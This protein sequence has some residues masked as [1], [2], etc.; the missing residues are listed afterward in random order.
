MIFIL[1][2]CNHGMKVSKKSRIQRFII[3]HKWMAG[4]YEW[5]VEHWIM[6]VIYLLVV[7]VALCLINLT[8]MV[9]L[10]R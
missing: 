10:D 2:S 5:L 6:A 7:A 1:K 8:I 3:R 9:L 4:T